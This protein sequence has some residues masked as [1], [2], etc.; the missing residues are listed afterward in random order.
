MWPTAK[1]QRVFVE[2]GGPSSYQH[3]PSR[4]DPAEELRLAVSL[5]SQRGRRLENALALRADEGH[6]RAVVRRDLEASAVDEANSRVSNMFRVVGEGS[7][8]RAHDAKYYGS[9]YYAVGHTRRLKAPHLVRVAPAHE[10]TR[11]RRPETDDSDD[12]SSR[13]SDDDDDD[14][15]SRRP[16]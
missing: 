4:L 9:T 13:T 10:P 8:L 11:P 15:F 6:R 7:P 12:D 14:S 16:Q 2:G 1:R 5:A 3:T